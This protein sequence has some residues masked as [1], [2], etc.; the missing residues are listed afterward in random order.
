MQGRK[1]NSTSNFL[2]ENLNL[3][4]SPRQTMVPA[5]GRNSDIYVK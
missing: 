5:Q 4:I 1:Q 3:D 2:W